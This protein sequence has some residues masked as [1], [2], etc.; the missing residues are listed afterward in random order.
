MERNE[1]D[2]KK[3]IVGKSKMTALAKEDCKAKGYLS[4]KSMKRDI[5]RARIQMT[6]GFKGNFLNMY[7]GGNV[8]CA[9]CCQVQET[10][11]HATECPAYSI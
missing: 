5:F 10:Q 7:R 4:T 6:A 11:S 8:N 9:G 3:D 1:K 2:L